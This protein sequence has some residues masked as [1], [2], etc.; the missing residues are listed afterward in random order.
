VVERFTPTFARITELST[1]L[2]PIG[3]TAS[4]APADLDAATLR[5][6]ADRVNEIAEEQDAAD[7]PTAG[8][9]LN[10]ALVTAYEG[11]GASLGDLADAVEAQDS[12]AVQTAITALSAASDVFIGD[13]FTKLADDLLSAC[14]DLNSVIG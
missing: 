13:E 12:A 3:V 6:A 7:P 5:Q 8:V 4:T 2:T 10:D 14:P 11:I 9:A 1:L